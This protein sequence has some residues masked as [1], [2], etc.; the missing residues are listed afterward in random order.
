MEG[1]VANSSVLEDDLE[2]GGTGED[3]VGFRPAGA[4]NIIELSSAVDRTLSFSRVFKSSPTPNEPKEYPA[5]QTL[6]LAYQSLGV[7]YGD[8]ATSPVN[9]F[10]ATNLTNVTAE[11]LLG[12]FSLMFWSLTIIVWIKYVFIVIHADDHGE[13]G[14]FALYSY[15]RRHINFRTKFTIQNTRLSTDESMRFSNRPSPLRSKTKEFIE[16][17]IR[18]QN[19]IIVIVLLGTCMVIGDGALTP[20]TSVLS[21][22][23]GVQSLS[24]K[25]TQDHVVFTS[26][27][28]L[29]PLFLFQR[30][31]TSK[32]SF[33]FS[34][35]MLLWLATNAS[36][37]IYNIFKYYPS[38][39][40]AVSPHYIVLFSSR[41]AKTL[42][43][44]LGAVFLGITGAEAMFADL[45]HFNKQAIQ[46]AFSFVVYPALIITYAGETAYLIKY[47]EKINNAYY[48][49]LPRP[50][51]WPMFVISTLAAV[52][53]S[54]SMISASFSIVKQS[55]TLGCFPPVKM[56]HTS[57]K[58]EGQVYSPEVN[59]AL[60][61]LCVGLVIGFKG[62]VAL[63]NAYGVV[64]IWVMLI[65]TLLTSLVMLVI[66]N[67]NILLVLGFLVPYVLIEG[68]FMTS[69]LNK[70]PQGGWVPFAISAILGTVMLSWTYGRSKKSM[71][72][73]GG[74][75]SIGELNQ[76]L[77]STCIFRTPGICFF[78]TDL[79][80]GIPPIIR[81]YIQHTNSVREIMV[82]VTIR[83]L[84][85]K[86]VLPEERFVVGRLGVEGVY[87][88]L[89]QLGY[90]DSL[91]MEG[92][93]YAREIVAKLR[94]NADTTAEQRKLHSAS[95]NETVFVMGRTIL[96]ANENDGWLARFTIEYLYRFLQ[97][98]CRSSVSALHLP[99][100]KTMQVGMLYRL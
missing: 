71:Y 93:D 60:M 61:I 77:S 45:G 15:L 23:Q 47:P 32:V 53:A 33:T 89:V 11:D 24:P 63:A 64:V 27:A 57:S 9:V 49:C 13:G 75:M 51:Y 36:I 35:I 98:N 62:G 58:H 65:T 72:E 56:V 91:N 6:L 55:L 4:G 8:L 82:V 84:P 5:A 95:E 66:W 41:N 69:M 20:A 2:N 14:T 12:T 74:K 70:I 39:L 22:V 10:S 76:K 48:S 42:W 40:K 30:C 50:V 100:E 97:K 37:G 87:R 21:A 99:P 26:V 81:H 31:G 43:N 18:A 17:S 1:K 78:F 86:T 85:I 16:R 80:D 52:V 94:G 59:Y 83:T 34:P 28:V 46:W 38:I 88:C 7:V 68:I 19:F 3:T 79:V 73:G 96:A 92:G 44:L 29:I 90:K 25:I 54:Q 67:S